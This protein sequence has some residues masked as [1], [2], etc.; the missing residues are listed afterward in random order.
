VIILIELNYKLYPCI[1][2]L[3]LLVM[4][5]VHA[6]TAPVFP[7]LTVPC[8]TPSDIVASGVSSSRSDVGVSL[9]SDACNEFAD[10]FD[11]RDRFFGFDPF[12][13]L[14]S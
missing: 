10:S 6:L 5:R 13:V 2:A 4:L 7:M 8:L 9:V 14:G 11:R 12:A 1:R 3:P